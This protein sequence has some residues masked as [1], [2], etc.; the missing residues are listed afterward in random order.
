[1][2]GMPNIWTYFRSAPPFSVWHSHPGQQSHVLITAGVDGDEYAGIQAAEDLITSYQG[3]LPLTVIPTVNRAG[4]QVGMSANPLD[5]RYPKHI[6]PGSAYGSSSSRLMHSLLPHLSGVEIWIDLHGGASDEHLRPF[7]WTG[8]PYPE[9]SGLDLPLVV[10]SPANLAPYPYCRQHGIAYIL[11][12][13]GEL[14]IA[15]P[16]MVTLHH[17]VIAQ[18]LQNHLHPPLHSVTPTYHHV[19]FACRE[20]PDSP[21]PP[22][23]LW[24]SPQTLALGVW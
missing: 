8:A 1:M 5:G 16:E 11:V 17:Q 2:A 21:I 3:D 14:G 22:D 15:Q 9:L 23:Y 20:S 10:E 4:N 6:F 13:A 19:Q 12:E 24:Y 18:I 7:I